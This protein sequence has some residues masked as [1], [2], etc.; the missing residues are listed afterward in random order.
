MTV[1]GVDLAGSPRRPTGVCRLRGLSAST[2]VLHEDA[3]ILSYVRNARPCLVAVDAPLHL[4]PGRRTIDDRNGRHYRPC[5]LELRRLGIPFFPITLGPMRM[6]TVR[7][8]KLKKRLARE[9][10]RVVEIY[11]GAAQDVWKIPRARRDLRKLRAGLARLGD[12]DAAIALM[13]LPLWLERRQ[14]WHEQW[15]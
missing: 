11:P 7:G 9:G 6:L 12:V 14:Q 8:M 4:P 3:E 1:V 5:D 2:A 15:R 10:F 13:P